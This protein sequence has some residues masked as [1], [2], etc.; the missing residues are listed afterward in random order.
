MTLLAALAV[1]LVAY[2]AVGLVTG[3]TSR[4]GTRAR[5][6]RR[7]RLDRGVWLAQAGSELSTA[8]FVAGSLAAGACTFVL[9]ALVTGDPV[10]AVVPA[11][12]V[13]FLPGAF[14][15]RRRARRLVEIQQAWPDGIRHIIGGIQSGMSLSVA[16]ASLAGAGP[17]PLRLAFERFGVSARMVG[18][19]AALEVVKEQ[20]ADPT[21]DRVIEVLL[22]AH[23]RGGRIVT[24]VLGDLAA[25]TAKDLK[26]M[27]EI[28]SDRLEPKINSRAVFALPWLVLVLL[29]ATTGPIRAFYRTA[30]GVAVIVLA[31]LMSLLGLWVVERLSR[32][33]VEERVFGAPARAAERGGGISG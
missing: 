18:I 26:T 25:A 2:L 5:R 27:E 32:D 7:Q 3:Y 6:P 11:T 28:A 8:Q 31:A 10:V 4:I 12:A 30:P 14:F 9:V 23:E 1:G 22:L 33:P 20:L 29:T 13:G 24:E 19:P 15:S 21:S 16:I 17:Q